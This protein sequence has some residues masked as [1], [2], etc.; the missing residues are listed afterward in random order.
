M[1]MEYSF[2]WKTIILFIVGKLIMRIGGRK[3]ISQ[4]TQIQMITMIGFGTVLVGPIKSE[5]VLTTLMVLMLLIILMIIFEY[6]ETK[7]DFLETLFTGKS[8]M[9]IDKGIINKENLKK[10]RMT[11]DKLE[12]Q[13]RMNSVS[14]IND[15]EYATIEANGE[16][17]FILKKEK[18]PVTKEDLIKLLQGKQSTTD[19]KL[20]KEVKNKKE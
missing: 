9:V 19:N 17:G 10:I 13:L 14:S 15:V 6:L 2:I 16:I 12:M 11:V 4:M 20:F 8:I 7:F 18:K 1:G 5:D 3:T